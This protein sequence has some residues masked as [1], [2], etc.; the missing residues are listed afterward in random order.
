MNELNEITYTLRNKKTGKIIDWATEVL[1]QTLMLQG[2]DCISK[3]TVAPVKAEV[4]A[5][6]VITE[7]TYET[8]KATELKKLNEEDLVNDISTDLVTIT[9]ILAEH[10]SDNFTTP[11]IENPNTPVK[12]NGRSKKNKNN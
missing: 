5:T 6:P 11:I 4:K 7:I 10:A 3:N 1:A 2:W 9:E 12:S 8:I